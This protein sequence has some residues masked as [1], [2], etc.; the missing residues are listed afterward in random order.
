MPYRKVSNVLKY[1]FDS[2]MSKGVTSLIAG[3]FILSLVFV[4]VI[5]IIGA[6]IGIATNDESF[7]DF[8]RLMWDTV[9][10]SLDGGV[11][12]ALHTNNI[13]YVSLMLI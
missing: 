5:S 11:I 3:L 9:L 4:L 8:G 2:F 10:H 6:I 12:S 13:S 1:K 7:A